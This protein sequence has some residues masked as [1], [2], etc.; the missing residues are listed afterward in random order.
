MQRRQRGNPGNFDVVPGG[1][2]EV[3]DVDVPPVGSVKA[4]SPSTI[5]ASGS[6]WTGPGFVDTL[7][8]QRFL[9]AVS[10][11]RSRTE[12]AERRMPSLSVV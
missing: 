3:G 2:V 5:G 4:G 12:V 1:G 6:P 8:C 10:L 7:S 9:F 11:E